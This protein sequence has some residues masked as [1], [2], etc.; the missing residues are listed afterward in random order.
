MD[1]NI[2]Q[3]NSETECYPDC[4]PKYSDLKMVELET[5]ELR[6]ALLN[7]NQLGYELEECLTKG[8]PNG[9]TENINSTQEIRVSGNTRLEELRFI[10][11]KD[12]NLTLCSQIVTRLNRIKERIL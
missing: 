11:E 4:C 3:Q 8:L 12:C 9:I 7:I 2:T 5:E 1:K 10:I 6:K